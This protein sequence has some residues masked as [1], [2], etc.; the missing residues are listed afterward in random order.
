MILAS[1]GREENQLW[2][3]DGDHFTEVG[4]ALGVAHDDRQDYSDDQSYRCYCAA[5]PTDKTCMPA[6][7]APVVTCADAFGSGSGPYF[8][9]WQ[10]GFSDQP[11]SLGGNYFTIACGDIDDDGDMDLLTA[12]IVHGDTG[13]SA[14][15]SEIALNPGDGTKLTRPGN[16][17]NGLLRKHSGVYWNDGDSMAVMVDVDLDGRKDVM[18][19]ETGAYGVQ[20]PSAFFHQ[21]SDGTFEE[22]ETKSGLVT[23]MVRNFTIPAWIDI[24]GDGDLDLVTAQTTATAPMIVYRN[25]VAQDQN[26]L[27]VHLDGGAGTGV[28]RSAIGAIVRV[29]AG[30]RTQTQVVSGGYGHGNV[31]NDFVLTFGLGDACDVDHIDV[32]WPDANTTTTTYANIVANYDVTLTFGKKDVA[33]GTHAY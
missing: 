11:Y 21:K 32:R 22:L 14:D 20:D 18:W 15:P 30:G 4:L 3:N 8:R 2:R 26:M 9:G 29:T 25:D 19:T 23:S 13:S 33:Y 1:Y 5:N 31:Q 24:D 12:T 6:P 10:P 28:N 27:R 16:D 7:P 17:K